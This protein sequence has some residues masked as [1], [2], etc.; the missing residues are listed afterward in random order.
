MGTTAMVLGIVAAIMSIVPGL[1]YIAWLFAIPAV[2]LGIIG[3]RKAGHPHGRAL[4]GLIEGAAA[5]VVAIAVSVASAGDF[6][7]GFKDGYERSRSAS[8]TEAT[9]APSK[10]AET[11]PVK[12][13]KPAPV[14]AP[15]ASEPAAKAPAEAESPADGEFG[16]YPADEAAFIAGVQATTADLRG[17]LTDL[18]RSQALRNRDASLCTTLGDAAATDWTGKIKNIGANGEGKA[19]VEVEIASGITVMTWNNAF[20]DLNDQ[21]LIDPSAPFFNNLVAMKEGQKVKFSAQ[22]AAGDSSCLSKGNLTETFY[23]ITPEFIAHFTNVT[24]A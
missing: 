3:L 6:S 20:S 19:Y 7:D 2:I 4:A 1:S 21:T 18:Q 9:Q 5:L 16:T 14:P 17:D 22:M 8:T 15:A 24:S 10:D 13:T 23:G 12:S 11:T